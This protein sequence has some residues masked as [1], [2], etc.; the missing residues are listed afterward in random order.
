MNAELSAGRSAVRALL[1]ATA[2]CAGFFLLRLWH[3]G[4]LAYSYLPWNLFLAWLP[5]GLTVLLVRYLRNHRWSSWGAL[6]LTFLWLLFL[7]N[8]FYLVSDYIHLTDVSA[9]RAL[10][11]SVMFSMFVFTGLLLGYAS[12]YGVHLQLRHRLPTRQAA[13]LIAAVL[14]VCSFAMYVGRDLRRN[15]WDV[16]ASPT[17]LL[18]DLSN[19]FT[20]ADHA[21]AMVGTVALFFAF[22]L[23]AYYVGLRMMQSARR[24]D[25]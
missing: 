3:A 19:Q 12:L 6:G 2:I 9:D 16:L 22:L 1:V 14:L 15:S 10:Y 11:D 7:P 5:L 4:E 24:I 17:G 21:R 18:F 25:G 20:S 13:V 23:G 8:S